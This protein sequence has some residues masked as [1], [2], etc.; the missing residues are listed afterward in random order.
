MIQIV[1]KVYIKVADKVSAE[2]SELP[3]V[4]ASATIKI[5]ISQEKAGLLQTSELKATL[6]RESPWLFRNLLVNVLL[7]DGTTH[8]FGS[9]DL[10]VRFSYERSSARKVSFKYQ[11]KADK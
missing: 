4:P 7:D 8:S 6:S 10:P 9:I 2:W 1:K 11:T 5:E 3:I